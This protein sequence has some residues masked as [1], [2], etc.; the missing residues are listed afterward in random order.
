MIMRST[1]QYSLSTQLKYC[2]AC[3]ILAGNHMGSEW[4]GHMLLNHAYEREA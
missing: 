1:A 3:S 4:L 2:P